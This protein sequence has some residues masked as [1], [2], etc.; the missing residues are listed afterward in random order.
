MKLERAKQLRL[1][2]PGPDPASDARGVVEDHVAWH[3]PDVLE[4][5]A[6]P[7]GHAFGGLSAVGVHEAHVREREGH[8]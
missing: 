3:G 4:L 5:G 8:Q 1:H 2:D 6:Q 7:V